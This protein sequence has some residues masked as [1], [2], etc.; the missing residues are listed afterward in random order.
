MVTG[1][2]GR[3][4]AGARSQEDDVFLRPMFCVDG[5]EQAC[6]PAAPC[7]GLEP[8]PNCGGDCPPLGAAAGLPPLPT[9]HLP[10]PP[11][12]GRW[13]MGTMG[14]LPRSSSK[15]GVETGRDWGSWRGLRRAV[16]K[17]DWEERGRV[18][19]RRQRV[20]GLHLKPRR[21]G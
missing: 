19:G 11:W 1:R 8:R 10:S 16:E 3:R 17:G 15:R 18:R 14:T 4:G 20:T 6:G 21:S 9:Q 2:G 5:K 12:Y 7:V 13:S